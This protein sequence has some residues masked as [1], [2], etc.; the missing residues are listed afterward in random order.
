MNLYKPHS[1]KIRP[2]S[3]RLNNSDTN[4]CTNTVNIFRH[5]GEIIIILVKC[6]FFHCELKKKHVLATSFSFNSKR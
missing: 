3:I 4:Q 5:I 2:N 1:W 6:F